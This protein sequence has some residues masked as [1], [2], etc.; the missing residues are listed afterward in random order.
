MPQTMPL[1]VLIQE[2]LHCS[3]FNEKAVYRIKSA[4]SRSPGGCRSWRCYWH[5]DTLPTM[6]LLLLMV[7]QEKAKP[8][9][10]LIPEQHIYTSDCLLYIK[11]VAGIFRFS[12]VSHVAAFVSDFLVG[13]S[14]V[15]CWRHIISPLSSV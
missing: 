11:A 1:L 9:V 5:V 10:L 4:L 2:A 14:D 8:L 7:G 3:I 12:G 6:A 13:E 15:H